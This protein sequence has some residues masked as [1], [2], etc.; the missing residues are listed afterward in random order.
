M[1]VIRLVRYRMKAN[2][3]EGDSFQL[4]SFTIYTDLHSIKQPTNFLF[5]NSF[6]SLEGTQGSETVFLQEAYH[7]LPQTKACQ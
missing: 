3:E 2:E 4:P 6:S 1:A 5:Y 7:H